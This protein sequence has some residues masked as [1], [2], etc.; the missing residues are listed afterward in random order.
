MDYVRQAVSGVHVRDHV[1]VRVRVC[2]HVRVC[3]P[4][5]VRVH[6]HVPVRDCG[7]LKKQFDAP[8]VMWCPFKIQ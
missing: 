1:H 5:L 7:D 2:A 3:I 6:V 8:H 4:V